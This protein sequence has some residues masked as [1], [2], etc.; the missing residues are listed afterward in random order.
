M[1]RASRPTLEKSPLDAQIAACQKKIGY[2]FKS[3]QLLR[4]ALTHS[5]SAGTRLE[6]NER[7]EFLGDAVMGL[8]VCQVLY[9]RLPTAHEGELTKIKSAVV[10][11]KVCARVADRLRLADHML[12]GQGMEAGDHL[13]K[14]LA[15]CALEA[16]IAAVYL[17]G[18]IE[19]ARELILRHM[20]DEIRAATGSQH[21]YNYKSQ[22]QQ[23]AQR[24][25]NQTPLYE[26]LDEKGPDH[27][28]CFEVAVSI[29][30][31][32][33]PAAW[34][35]NKKE[36]EQKA[37]KLALHRLG[38]ISDDELEREDEASPESD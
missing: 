3:I 19:P 1:P 20:D 4:A 31:R 13:P 25:L 10:S 21:Q 23:H 38:L 8:V 7:M 2:K 11:R 18:G 27:A 6:S 12:L 9:E 30:D 37:A 35:T 5:S 26:M 16:V 28:R 15:A 33:Y 17:D 14:S 34:G 29:G 32:Q 36:A 24:N 22:L